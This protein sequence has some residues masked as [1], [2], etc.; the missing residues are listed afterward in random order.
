MAFE[1]GDIDLGEFLLEVIDCFLGKVAGDVE[2]A[3]SN[4]EMGEGLLH[5]ALDLLARIVL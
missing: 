1:I 4:E 3:I 2:I 5:E